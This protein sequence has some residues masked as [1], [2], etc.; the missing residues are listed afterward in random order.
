MEFPSLVPRPIAGRVFATARRVRLGD[1]TGSGRLRLDAAVRY[2]QDV[3][4]DDGRD[5]QMEDLHGWV[6]RRTSF[7]IESFPR[8]LEMLG[9]ET[10]CSGVGSHWAE[11]RTTLVSESGQRV[12][13]AALWVH[14]DLNSM[15]PKP[16]TDNFQSLVAEATN[17]RKIG[18]RHILRDKPSAGDPSMNWQLRSTDFDALDHVNNAAYWEAVEEIVK[19]HGGMKAPLKVVLE[20]H[21]A[22]ERGEK[23]TITWRMH[24]NEITIWHVVN[25]ERIAAVSRVKLLGR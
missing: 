5:A 15:W 4:N 9:I 6:V 7:E 3:A 16:L 17:G 8:Y 23:V 10:W 12:E 21:D 18:S 25:G 20:H 1:V 2:L 14:V 22:I 24:A 11:R 13:A 19:A